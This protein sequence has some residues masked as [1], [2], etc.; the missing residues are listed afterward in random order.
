MMHFDWEGVLTSEA[1]PLFAAKQRKKRKTVEAKL[2]VRILAFACFPSPCHSQPETLH[3]SIYYGSSAGWQRLWGWSG[4][5]APGNADAEPIA[6]AKPKPEATATV[7]AK[8]L[9]CTQGDPRSLVTF[10]NL[11]GPRAWLT[12]AW[13]TLLG[14]SS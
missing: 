4:F 5:K 9:G 2:S 3:A 7:K 6:K 13:V 11:L 14:P 1:V 10:A 12:F 8:A